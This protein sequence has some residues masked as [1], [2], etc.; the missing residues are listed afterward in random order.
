MRILKQ[1]EE[2]IQ[3][4]VVRKVMIN[5]ERAKSLF[6]ESERKMRSL[7]ERLEKL[8]VKNENAGDY[9]EYCYDIIMHL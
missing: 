3:E 5:R 4:G 9:I 2:Y 1:F 6:I 7:K 8:G